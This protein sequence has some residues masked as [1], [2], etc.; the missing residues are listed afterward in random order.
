MSSTARSMARRFPIV[1]LMLIAGVVASCGVPAA[2][3]DIG[4]RTC[5]TDDGVSVGSLPASLDGRVTCAHIENPLDPGDRSAGTI[6]IAVARLQA[7]GPREGTVVLNP[8]GPGGAGVAHLVATAPELA[9]L[10]L[11]DTHDIISF[12]PRGVGASRPSVRCRTDDERDAERAAD[13]GD[14][15]PAGIARIEA[16]QRLVAQRCRERTGEALLARVGTDFV[17]ADLDRIRGALGIDKIAFVGHSYGTRIGIGYARQFPSHVA[18][19]VLDG[20][21]DPAEDPVEASLDQL[22]GFQVAFDAF[23]DDCVRRPDC[24]LGDRA[25]EAVTNYQQLIRPLSDRPLR[26]GNRTLTGADAENGTVAALYQESSWA[27]L[28]VALRR[29]ADGAGADL[30]ALADR[31]AG[32]DARGHYDASQDAFL[33]ITCADQPSRSAERKVYD[34]FDRRARDVAPFRDDGRAGGHGPIGICES[35]TPAARSDAGPVSDGPFPPGVPR[36]LVVAATGDPATPYPT[37]VEFARRVGAGF[38]GVDAMAHTA[39]FRGN[40]CVDAAA[41]AYLSDLTVPRGRLVC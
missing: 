39:V 20:V 12:D 8:G 7:R 30:L 35:W 40:R 38:I 29:L 5:G 9:A 31:F 21:V 11:A 26:V 14:R 24:A 28:R 17:V 2:D 37:A 15:T 3:D 34:E 6:S 16:H 4:W 22:R 19:L 33:A 41:T 13:F 10:G 32:R 23:A 27:R 36:G 1:V 18:G 25:D